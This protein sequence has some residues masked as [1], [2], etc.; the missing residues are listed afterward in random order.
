MHAYRGTEMS[1]RVANFACA[2]IAGLFG[3]VVSAEAAD[4]VIMGTGW[5]AQAEHGGFYQAVADGTYAKYG[6]DVSILMGGPQT[7]TEAK[8]IAGQIQF[9]QG[10][11]L[12]AFDAV[13]NNVPLITVAAIFQKDPQAILAHPDQGIEKIDDLA[14]LDTLFLAGAGYDT[15]FRWMKSTNPAFKDEKVKPY[16]F[17]P[18]PFIANPKSGQQ[19]YITSE[20][21]AIKKMAGWDPKAFLLADYGYAAYA[22][23]IETQKALY[24]KNPDL[25]KRFVEASI[26][27]WYNYLYGDNKVANDLIKKDNPEMTDEQIAFSIAQ[28]KKYEIVSGGDAATKGIGC[29]T[30]EHYKTFFDSMAKAGVLKTD[31]DYKKAYTNEFVCKGLGKELAK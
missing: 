21:F 6:L 23:T 16:T 3:A 9:M 19:A 12:G 7:P 11:T 30:D 27:G 31:L 26:I 8:L 4:K 17:N 24:E 15:Y 2:A 29:M 25:V 1:N 22:T 14:K 13:A 18:A 10:G 5:L 20:P 28:L